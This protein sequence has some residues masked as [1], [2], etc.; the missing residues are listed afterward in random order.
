LKIKALQE[1]CRAF[2]LGNIDGNT[3]VLG[4]HFNQFINQ[5]IDECNS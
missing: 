2:L 5:K 1:Y 3:G 4:G